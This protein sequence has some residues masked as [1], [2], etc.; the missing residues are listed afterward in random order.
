[1]WADRVEAGRELSVELARRGYGGDAIVLGVPRG[2]VELAA[3]V[4]RV[5]GAPLDIVV[6]RKVG[7][8]GNPEFAAGA[9]DPDGHVYP[10]PDAR[11]SADYLSRQGEIE[12]AEALRRIAEYRGGRP[13]LDLAGRTVI[14]VDDGIATGLT[15]LAAARWLRSR[16][17][18][19]VV[20]AVPVMS[21]S[22]SEMLSPE[23]DELVALEIPA[24]FYAVGAHYARFGQLTDSD[25]K[26]LL[27]GA[28][29]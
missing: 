27:V 7:A 26:E 12:H 24:G 28:Q 21:R 20:L 23:V 2:G 15:A 25:V 16:G 29:V 14:V 8:P 22:A 18:G 4:S 17:V 19:R 13:A 6:V 11:V 9:V 3:E 5:L 10:N 1:M